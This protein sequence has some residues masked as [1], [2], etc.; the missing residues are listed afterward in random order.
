MSG[1]LLNK[2]SFRAV[3]ESDT[4]VLSKSGLFVG[5]GYEC[6]G[7]FKFNVMTIRPRMNNNKNN[8]FAY[9]LRSSN[10]C[11]GRLGHVNYDTL[12]F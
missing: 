11:Y 2:H 6:R 8:S 7:M 12:I 1:S 3:F 9:M 4:M 5:K 10:L